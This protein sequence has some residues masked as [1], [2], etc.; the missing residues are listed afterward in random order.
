MIVIIVFSGVTIQAVE[1]R[2][3]RKNELERSL[4]EAMEQSMKI[5]TIHPLQGIEAAQKSDEFAAD[6]I[7]GFLVKITS[8]SNFTI[9]ILGIDVE[10]GLLD[11][12]VIERYRQIIGH[13]EISCRKTV[14][15]EDVEEQEDI[16][17]K[18]SFWA[19]GEETKEKPAGE[20]VT[21]Q[22]SVHSGGNL[23]L[24]ILPQNNMER[25]G[26]TFRGWRMIKPEDR[27]GVLYGKENIETLKVTEDLEFKAVY[28]KGEHTT[29]QP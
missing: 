27:N 9:E 13:G 14:I 6:F 25:K 3:I 15:L 8:N 7:Q 19:K 28:Q 16:F 22:V 18:V 5:L 4:G 12:R 1:N 24:A 26:Y 20:Y 29:V 11:V 10:K 21:K 23:N 2:S 17:Y